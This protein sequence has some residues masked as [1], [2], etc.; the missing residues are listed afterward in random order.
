M[1]RV[2]SGRRTAAIALVGALA[3]VVLGLVLSG[4]GGEAVYRAKALAARDKQAPLTDLRAPAGLA[5]AFE[6]ARGEPRLVLFL[7]PT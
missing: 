2:R 6:R 3:V 5:A 4:Y 1:R 7:S